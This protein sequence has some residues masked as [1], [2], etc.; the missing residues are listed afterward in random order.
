MLQANRK[1]I[2]VVGF[3]NST[4]TQEAMHFFGQES[5]SQVICITPEEFLLSTARQDY[6]YI[7]GF[8]LDMK[9]RKK[10]IDIINHENLD[11]IRY[12]HDSVVCYNKN[13][14]Q[15][16]GPGCFVAPFTTILLNAKIG[17]HCVIESNCLIAHNVKLSENVILHAGTM[18]AGGVHVGAN[19]V[20]QFKASALPK[21]TLCDNIEVGATSTLTKDIYVPGLYVG[22][23]ARRVGSIETFQ[24][25]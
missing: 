7:V 22:T 10:V 21:L 6:Q 18:L 2:A 15:V 25:K 5:K 20:F 9:Q 14:E 16:F 24:E 4:M 17:A 11:C 3:P 1:T 19:T 8:S 13:F 12:V 23:P